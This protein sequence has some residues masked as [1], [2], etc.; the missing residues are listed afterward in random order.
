MGSES[1]KTEIGINELVDSVINM[2]GNAAC[3]MVVEGLCVKPQRRTSYA[4]DQN[5]TRNVACLPCLWSI[6]LP[7]GA[8]AQGQTK[9]DRGVKLP[10]HAS[11]ETQI[12]YGLGCCKESKY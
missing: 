5:E 8:E 4:P 12:A 3:Q 7:C 11:D 10:V 2:Q 1:R 6:C 9:N